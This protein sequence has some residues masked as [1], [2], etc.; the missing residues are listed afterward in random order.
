MIRSANPYCAIIFKKVTTC[1]EPFHVKCI[2]FTLGT[3]P[4]PLPFVKLNKPTIYIYHPIA[5]GQK[6]R[7]ISEYHVES[8]AKIS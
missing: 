3:Y 1:R 8:A 7:R 2:N 6:I 4:I 5:C